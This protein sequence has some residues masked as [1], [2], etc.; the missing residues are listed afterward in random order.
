MKFQDAVVLNREKTH[1]IDGGYLVTVA[2]S[3]RTGIQR[4]LG[5]EMGLDGVDFIDVYRPE[6]EVFSND[7][8]ASFSH[9][10]ITI[11]HPK[12]MVDSKNWG[13]LAVGEVS[14]AAKKDGEWVMLPLILKDQAAIDALRSGKKELSAGYNSEIEFVDGVAPDGTPYQAVQRNIR[15]N[16]LALVD[17]ARAGS[18][19]RIEDG[20]SKWGISPKQ[21]DSKGDSDMSNQAMKTVLVDGISI[22]TT[23]QGAQVIAKLQDSIAKLTADHEKAIADK[24]VE[25]ATKDK[26]IADKDVKIK[27]LEDKV[28]DE[29]A[30][31]ARVTARADL[32]AKA[33]MV[34]ADVKTD[35]LS[36][37][38]IR[39]AV[40]VASVGDSVKDKSDA[41]IEARFDHL[42]EEHK[43]SGDTLKVLADQ[44]TRPVP[45][46]VGGAKA[47]QAAYDAS[48]SDLNAWR[49][50]K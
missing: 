3:V 41:Y 44:G 46:G 14:T 34:D 39:R 11:D 15:I 5:S 33:K 42:V 12:E 36:D 43:D 26:E 31:D 10:P 32:I 35:G 4:Y 38:A 17:R 50:A 24:D 30:L 40:V 23:D 20:A 49:N 27:G 21:M 47:Q 18:K 2:R 1:T 7:S 13:Y 19:A 25:I 8:L 28:L 37:A 22:E 9:A 16:H 6:E 45:A 29:S 48:V